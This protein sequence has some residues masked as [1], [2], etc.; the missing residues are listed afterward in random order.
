MAEVLIDNKTKGIDDGVE[1]SNN[2]SS[3]GDV[4][5]EQKMAVKR[6]LDIGKEKDYYKILNVPEDVSDDNLKKAFRKLALE[7][8]PDKNRADGATEAFK[9]LN[10]AYEVL[11]N[12]EKREKYDL[13]G[14][15]RGASHRNSDDEYFNETLEDIFQR[16]FERRGS[17]FHFG[18]PHEGWW[19][20]PGYTSG[21]SQSYSSRYQGQS[22]GYSQ[23]RSSDGYSQTYS[24][25]YQKQSHTSDFET[26]DKKERKRNVKSVF[27]TKGSRDDDYDIDMVLRKLGETTVNSSKKKSEKK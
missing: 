2:N 1:D 18:C 5:P 9:L 17:P 3:M 24:S 21:Y 15:D 14:P 4:S 26:K 16:L 22:E 25:K 12:P 23:R 27:T 13:Y 7:I 6:I 11:S 8:H 19:W 10:T 20:F